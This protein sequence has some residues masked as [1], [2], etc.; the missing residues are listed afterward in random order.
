MTLDSNTK[1][2]T[3]EGLTTCAFKLKSRYPS[4]SLWGLAEKKARSNGQLTSAEWLE[5][6]VGRNRQVVRSCPMP[7]VISSADQCALVVKNAISGLVPQFQETSHESESFW[8]CRR[9]D[10]NFGT[11]DFQIVRSFPNSSKQSAR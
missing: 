5:T 10:C 6:G 3:S 1:H 9:L 11:P 8:I 2:R 4:C 7:F